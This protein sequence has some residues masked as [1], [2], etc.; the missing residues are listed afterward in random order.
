MLRR[1][2]ALQCL[3]RELA[4]CERLVLLGDVLEL[5]QLPPAQ[6]MEKAR[7]VLRAI[8][9]TMADG[10]VILVPGNHDHELLASWFEQDATV[11]GLAPQTEVPV[12]PGTLLRDLV[13]GLSPAPVRVSYPGLWLREDVYATHGHYL[14]RHTTIPMLERLGAGAMA[15]L[16][17]EPI[18][19][20][21]SADDYE[22]V[23]APIYAWLHAIALRNRGG[24]DGTGTG[25]SARAWRALRSPSGP[26]VS[27]RL[28]RRLLAIGF[29]GL[30]HALN[31]SGL[32]PL[33]ADLTG[34]ALRAASL[35]AFGEVLSRL[36]IDASHVIFG[37]T[38]RAGPL[39]F[40]QPGSWRTPAGGTLLNTGCW[41][42]DPA[43]L[44]VRPAESPYRPGFTVRLEE[45]RAPRLVN[46]LDRRPAPNRA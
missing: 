33:S 14:D 15:R 18:A 1:P 38:H 6:V 39:A 12:L 17:G 4:D 41:V 19:G 10:E 40:D 30:V 2:W 43:F 11:A 20:P 5:R 46:L 27:R 44:G 35:Q 34:P 31:R 32:G 28:R 25:A 36:G 42:H 13:E 37:H 45:G 16:V 7:P 23:L 29:P 8:G 9:G 24:G 22:R 21:V 3:C 26:A